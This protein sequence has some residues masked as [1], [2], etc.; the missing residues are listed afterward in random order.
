[1]AE[2]DSSGKAKANGAEAHSSWELKFSSSQ[3]NAHPAL[4]SQP[5]LSYRVGPARDPS[6]L[7]FVGMTRD[8]RVNCYIISFIFV[9]KHLYIITFF[10]TF[11]AMNMG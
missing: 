11:A 4:A 9:G 6:A 2:T 3:T 5:T 8:V 7:R 1:M 10:I